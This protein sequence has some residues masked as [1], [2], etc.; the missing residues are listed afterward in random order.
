MVI[1]I[2]ELFQERMVH[3]NI[4]NERRVSY[5]TMIILAVITGVFSIALLLMPD[6]ELLSFMLSMAGLGG[7]IGGNHDYNERER[8][9]LSQSYRTAFEWL[10]IAMMFA[11]AMI[12]TSRW[13]NVITGVASFLNSHWPVL[14]ISLMCLFMGMAGLPRIGHKSSV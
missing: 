5:H 1:F 2:I 14:I 8:Q 3:V 10:L 7:L 11:F 12:V 6:G 9:Q 4:N 13:L